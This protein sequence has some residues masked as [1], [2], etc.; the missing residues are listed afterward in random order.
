MKKLIMG[1]LLATSML[2]TAFAANNQSPGVG[3]ILLLQ[4]L[5][6]GSSIT[7]PASSVD[8]LKR[9]LGASEVKQSAVQSQVFTVSF[10]KKDV[11]DT[12][13]EHAVK[14]AIKQQLVY[15]VLSE[16]MNHKASAYVCS[17]DEQTARDNSRNS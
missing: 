2:T 16:N 6:S 10:D 17:L 4:K 1:T 14:Q 3:A 13:K 15:C 12:A 8:A 7:V 5:G 11:N 9:Q